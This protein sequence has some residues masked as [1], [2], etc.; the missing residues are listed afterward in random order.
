MWWCLHHDA[1]AP[2]TCPK[3]LQGL[4]EEG[5]SKDTACK[6]HSQLARRTYSAG[7]TGIGAKDE[8]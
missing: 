5:A 3:C 1:P 7:T 6:R 8:D 4:L 2:P